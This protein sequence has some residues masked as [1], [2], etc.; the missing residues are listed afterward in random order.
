[1]KLQILKFSLPFILALNLSAT[2]IY[3][4]DDLILKAM[5][6]SPDLKIASAQYLASK[7]KLTIA[8]SDYLPVV[9][10]QVSAGQ[11]GQSDILNGNPDSMVDSS[12]ILGTIS[13]KQLIYDFDKTRDRKSV[14]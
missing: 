9:D 12:G 6:N 3:N 1:M 7:E 5:D 8:D 11:F 10:L 2:D 4:V 14:V 13:A